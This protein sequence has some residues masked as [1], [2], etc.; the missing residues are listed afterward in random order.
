MEVLFKGKGVQNQGAR[1]RGGADPKR[2]GAET[3]RSL[4]S[5]L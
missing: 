1:K 4:S 2:A 3:M 5:G